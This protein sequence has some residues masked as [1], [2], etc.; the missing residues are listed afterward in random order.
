MTTVGIVAASCAQP[1]AQVIEKEV[2]VERIVKET[3]IVEKEVPIE[4][5]VKETVVVGRDVVVEKVVT[6]TPIPS[7]FNEAPE[8]ASMVRAGSLPPVD[9]RLPT[10]PLV[11]EPVESIGTYGGTLNQ[12]SRSSSFGVTGY[13]YQENFIRWKRDWTGH[14]ANLITKWEWNGDGTAITLHLRKGMKW[15]DGAPIT[16]DDWLFWF[17]D[18]IED[19]NIGLPRQ[20][21]T[22]P[23]G[24]AMT[25]AKL[26]GSVKYCV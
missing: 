25:T 6:A 18:M 7:S 3:V 10:E 12:L 1:T 20:T 26:D 23:G 17:N 13:W 16:W 9:E 5:V 22:H 2:P 8:F 11:L 21:G 19:E 4:R 14:R 15:S 24:Q